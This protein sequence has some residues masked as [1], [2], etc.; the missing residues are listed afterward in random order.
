VRLPTVPL[1]M[2]VEPAKVKVPGRG[3]GESGG[4]A[5]ASVGSFGVVA[6]LNVPL[7]PPEVGSGVME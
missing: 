5:D 2:F 6:L 7:V 1:C 3:A 4:V